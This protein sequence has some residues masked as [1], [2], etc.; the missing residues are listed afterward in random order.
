ML[1]R[2]Q[3]EGELEGI[4]IN[5]DAS[6]EYEGPLA[7]VEII[8]NH[9]IADI[10]PEGAVVSIGIVGPVSLECLLELVHKDIK[11]AFVKFLRAYAP[12]NIIQFSTKKEFDMKRLTFLPLSSM[13]SLGD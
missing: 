3:S 13:I 7:V 8:P 4:F 12:K 11:E 1:I 6:D 5:L 10:T 2:E 9:L